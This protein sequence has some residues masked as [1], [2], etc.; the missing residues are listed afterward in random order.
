MK[1]N[2]SIP[3]LTLAVAFFALA[4]TQKPLEKVHQVKIAQKELQWLQ[5]QKQE[6]DNFFEKSF[7]R[8]HRKFPRVN[9]EKYFEIIKGQDSSFCLFQQ[10]PITEC[11]DFGDYEY[12]HGRNKSSKQA[13][14]AAI[15]TE[16]YN[17]ESRNTQIYGALTQIALEE[18]DLYMAQVYIANILNIN[19][20]NKWAKN[21]LIDVLSSK[22]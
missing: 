12:K 16:M 21:K 10:Y 6:Q 20:N 15:L 4:C 3:L 5:K 22:E 19:S 1:K 8:F 7:L 18:N 13:Y 9:R 2:L 11:T 14:L 17:S